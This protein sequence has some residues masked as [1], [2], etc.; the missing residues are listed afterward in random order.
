[1]GGRVARDRASLVGLAGSTYPELDD[2]FRPDE[3]VVVEQR[4]VTKDEPFAGGAD[5]AGEA[6]PAETRAD[7]ADRRER[8][9][10]DPLG[11]T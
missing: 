10:A 3:S 8:L 11:E 6:G 9:A 7:L 2:D 1:M 5:F 4:L